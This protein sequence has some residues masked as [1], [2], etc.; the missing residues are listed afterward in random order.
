MLGVFPV[1]CTTSFGSAPAP[2]ASEAVQDP[3]P[4]KDSVSTEP[5]QAAEPVSAP[6]AADGD[7]P[8]EGGLLKDLLDAGVITQEEYDAI[9]TARQAVSE[10]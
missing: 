9:N 3:V 6:A 1:S 2:A 8:A 7:A 4:A 5:R 10:T